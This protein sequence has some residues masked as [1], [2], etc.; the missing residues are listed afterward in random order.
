MP[1]P[2]SLSIFEDLIYW[3]D[4][5]LKS[6]NVASKLHSMAHSVEPLEST[7]SSVQ[8]ALL[9]P[10]WPSKGIGMKAPLRLLHSKQHYPMDIVVFH[11]LRQPRPASGWICD[12]HRCSDFCLPNNRTYVCACPTGFHLNPGTCLITNTLFWHM[13]A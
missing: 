10:V 1:N 13:N 7:P 11:P 12:D 2:F 6:I 3:T 4:W 9:R 8:H 5:H